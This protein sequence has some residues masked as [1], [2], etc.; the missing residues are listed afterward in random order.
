MDILYY[1]NFCPNSQKVVQYISRAGLIDRINAICIDKRT[2]D[3]T[4]GQIHV[5]MENGK[6]IMLPPNIH[7][8]PALLVVKKNYNAIFGGEIIKYF[9]PAVMSKMKEANMLNGEPVGTSLTGATG[10]LNIISEQYTLY[11]LTPEEL[12][13]K[14]VGGRRPLHNYTSVEQSFTIPTPP[15]TYRPDKI[16][17]SVTIDNLTH[18]RDQDIKQ[19]LPSTPYG[20]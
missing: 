7:S 1:S 2:I 10:N 15:D 20:F 12:S 5:Q 13:A 9:E 3:P 14:G 4:T 17:Q 8:V 19:G 18:K 16:D 11:D 6:K